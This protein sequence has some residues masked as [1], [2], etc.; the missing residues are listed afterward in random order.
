MWPTFRCLGQNR[1]PYKRAALYLRNS[2]KLQKHIHAFVKISGLLFYRTCYHQV[3]PHLLSH[4]LLQSNWPAGPSLF[5]DP[6][7]L[8][9]SLRSELRKLRG[10]RHD[11]TI[12]TNLRWT[13]HRGSLSLPLPCQCGHC[14]RCGTALQTWSH[15]IGEGFHQFSTLL[16]ALI[17]CLW[18]ESK[19][20]RQ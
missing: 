14:A 18:V 12:V 17:L 3:R 4:N 6:C 19:W 15:P 1:G 8:I 9:L 16:F 2:L 13:R 7:T 20:L 10:K 5:H 11:V